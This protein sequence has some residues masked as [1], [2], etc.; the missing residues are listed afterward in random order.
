[1]VSDIGLPDGTGLDLMRELR[2]TAKL[3]GVALSGYGTEANVQASLEAGFIAHVTK[4]VN[5]SDLLQ[6]I[7]RLHR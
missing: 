4:P 1:L 5:Y 2:K 7:A 3:K 6:A